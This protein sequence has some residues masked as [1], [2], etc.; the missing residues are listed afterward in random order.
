MS[1]DGVA[2]TNPQT[3]HLHPPETT[4]LSHRRNSHVAATE[5]CPEVRLRGDVKCDE[6]I[7]TVLYLSQNEGTVTATLRIYA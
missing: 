2:M 7:R 4:W 5:S 3:D 6:I 1:G